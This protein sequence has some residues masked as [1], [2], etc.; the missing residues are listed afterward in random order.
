MYYNK[1]TII[2]KIFDGG[3]KNV[4]LANDSSDTTIVYK[5]CKPKND[6]QLERFK[7]ELM[8][9]HSQHKSCFPFVIDYHID[10]RTK[11]IEIIEEFIDDGSLTDR[12]NNIW[13]ENDCVIFL[14]KILE[15]CIELWS[16]NIVH[17][18]I[19][20][21]NIMFRKNG[22]LVLIDLGIARFIDY[23]SITNTL[24]IMGPCTPIYAAPE[25]IIN[26]KR[27]IDFR[28]DLF[29]I[30]IVVLQLFL[31]F[32]PFDPCK[33]TNSKADIIQ[34]ILAGVYASAKSKNSCSEYFSILTNKLLKTRQYQRFSSVD[35]L[36]KFI[37][38]NWG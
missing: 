9:L 11:E 14:K 16:K 24:N 7:R 13:T 10:E 29:S 22:E 38:T 28:T 37:S 17:R 8:F 27:F 36:N 2:R 15:P 12:L 5:L 4:F 19:K 33:I 20:P 30:G 23:S 34:N 31:G 25:Q 18:D 32:H 6:Y 26:Q 3:Q 1:L 35:E 21:D